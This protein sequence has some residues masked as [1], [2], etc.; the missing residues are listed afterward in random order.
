[1]TANKKFWISMMTLVIIVPAYTFYL[2]SIAEKK[3]AQMD[4]EMQE[5]R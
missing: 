4:I 3:Y 1:M 2:G 5:M